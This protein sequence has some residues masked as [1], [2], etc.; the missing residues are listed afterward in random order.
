MVPVQEGETALDVA[1]KTDRSGEFHLLSSQTATFDDKVTPHSFVKVYQDA[2]LGKVAYTDGSTPI[3]HEAVADNAVSNYYITSYSIYDDHS[4]TWIKPKNSGVV[5]S[6][7]D[8]Y[9]ADN[10]ANENMFYFSD[11]AKTGNSSAMTVTFYND[12]AVGDI[13]I[14]KAYNGD[15]NTKFYYDVTFA[16]LFGSGDNTFNDLVAYNM[17]TYDVVDTASGAIISRGLTYGTTGIELKG[18]QTAVISGVPVETRYQVTERAKSGTSLKSVVKTITGPDGEDIANATPTH[19]YAESFD[20]MTIADQG[21]RGTSN[22]YETKDGDKYYYNMIPRVSESYKSGAYKTTSFVAFTNEKSS[23]KIVFNYYD[24]GLTSGSPATISSDPTSYIVNSSLSD[25]LND[26]TGDNERIKT[27]FKEM[28]EAA[29]VEFQEQALT[30]NVVDDY[31]MWSS[32]ED[33]IKIDSGIGSLTNIYANDGNGAL[34]KDAANFNDTKYYH[35]NSLSQPLGQALR[36]D[37][38]KWVS[39]KKDSSYV[40]AESFVNGSDALEV[41]EINVWLYNTP[42]QYNVNIY[43][44][45]SSADLGAATTAKLNGEVTNIK[46]ANVSN[47]SSKLVN[48]KV[49][50]NQRLGMGLQDNNIDSS[51]YI[52]HYNQ[53]GYRSDIEPVDYITRDTF[54]DSTTGKKYRFAYWAYDPAGQVIASTNA[55]YYYRITNDTNL[56][57]VYSEVQLEDITNAG[58]TIY[59][60]RNDKYVDSKGVSR[61]RLNIMFNPYACEDNDKNLQQTA[62]VYINLSEK[63]AGYSDA[64]VIALFNAYRDQLDDIL[65]AKAISDSFTSNDNLQ[66]I[67]TSDESPVSVT[68]T[69]KGFVRNAKAT[70]TGFTQVTPTAKNRV[71]YT[72]SV[73]TSSLNDTKLMIIGAMYYNGNYEQDKNHWKISDNCLYYV[74]GVCK[75]LDFG[76]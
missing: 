34:Y 68:L 19:K 18:G 63:V 52:S 39:Y 61:T 1:G 58:L 65:K 17:I 35:T 37:G 28:I 53:P 11:Y 70:A 51:A 59:N 22:R 54:T 60:N 6:A 64:D 26:V 10:S 32:L 30:Q 46:V 9:A 43:G 31:V 67:K 23:V 66:F 41:N 76:Q 56:Y 25:E 20:A 62:M 45:K 14:S 42:H 38:A 33:A 7:N 74:N 13:R 29:A 4:A 48:Q 12:I 69:T 21:I 57:A 47:T 55:Y 2:A 72:L 75:S 49:Y 73:K 16:N 8:I 24:R 27:A 40:D 3:G 36:T 71:Q 15:K 44:V 5:N 50:Y